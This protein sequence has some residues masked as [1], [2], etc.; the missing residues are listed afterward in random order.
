MQWLG[1]WALDLS[2]RGLGT[3]PL[4]LLSLDMKCYQTSFLS[5]PYMKKS[6][7]EQLCPEMHTIDRLH[8]R[9]PKKNS[10]VFVLITPTSLVLKEL[11]FCIL[12]VPMRRV[13][14]ISI[15]R[16]EYFFGCHLCSWSIR[17]MMISINETKCPFAFLVNFAITS[18]KKYGE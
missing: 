17:C 12:S 4:I 10:F 6:I 8:K 1:H 7:T 5:L 18:G 15:K 16:K 14:L 2:A 13:T 3:G 9:W 11:F